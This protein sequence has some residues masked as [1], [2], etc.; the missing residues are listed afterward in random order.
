VVQEQGAG[1]FIAD[2]K[3]AEMLEVRLYQRD[4]RSRNYTAK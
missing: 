3:R 4:E 2:E 1:I